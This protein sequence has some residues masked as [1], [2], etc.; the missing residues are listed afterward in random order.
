MTSS[1]GN[2]FGITGHL[3]GEFTGD[4]EFP[5]QR[6]ATRSFDVFF[7]MRL[8]KR[9]SKQSSDW[10][11]ETPSRP[12]WRRCNATY[13]SSPILGGKSITHNKCMNIWRLWRQKQVSMAGISNYIPHITVR[14]NYL[15]LCMPELTAS[16]AETAVH[17]LKSTPTFSSGG[18]HISG[19]S[20]T[21]EEAD[22]IFT[23]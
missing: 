15:C 3:C 9:L 5:S 7:D 4:R 23:R 6:L 17:N 13:H 19:S 21:T 20:E 10:W 22:T 18:F 14:C 12:L 2:I 16:G 11:F 1:N 8:N